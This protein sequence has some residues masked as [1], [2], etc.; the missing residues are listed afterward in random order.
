[1]VLILKTCILNEKEGSGLSLPWPLPGE[2]H[3]PVVPGSCSYWEFVTRMEAQA[4]HC[5]TAYP[6]I[7][8]SYSYVCYGID[9]IAT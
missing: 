4:D 1:M 5:V 3:V 2:W 6:E 8:P 9:H 7:L